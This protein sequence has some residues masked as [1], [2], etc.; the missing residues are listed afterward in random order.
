MICFS[1][2]VFNAYADCRAP[3]FYISARS[4]WHLTGGAICFEEAVWAKLIDDSPCTNFVA[5][6]VFIETRAPETLAEPIAQ[7]I[8]E[9][10]KWKRAGCKITPKPL[11]R[12]RQAICDACPF[13]RPSPFGLLGHCGKCH[14]TRAK[15]F[16]LTSA[17]PIGKW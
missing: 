8:D 2:P 9:L 3:A 1:H 14:C 12:Q 13:W 16:L 5:P 11:R 7:F 15:T 6:Q 17:C 10:R 4:R